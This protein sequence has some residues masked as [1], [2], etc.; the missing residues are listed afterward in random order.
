M[1]EGRSEILKAAIVFS[2]LPWQDPEAM[3]WDWGVGW[4]L[5]GSLTLLSLWKAHSGHCW[6]H[7][8]PF[9]LSLLLGG[10]VWELGVSVSWVLSGVGDLDNLIRA[11][12]S[13]GFMPS[14]TVAQGC[15]HPRS[16][17]SFYDISVL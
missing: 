12:N 15:P 1:E 9:R 11:D 16:S 4:R 8:E 14:N 13:Q 5:M 10:H 17:P 7:K 3:K 2:D 6:P